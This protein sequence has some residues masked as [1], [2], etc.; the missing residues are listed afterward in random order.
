MAQHAIYIAFVFAL[1]AC[2]GSFL[3]VVVWRLPRVDYVDGEGVLKSFY[4][5]YRALSYPPS[6]CPKC[7]KPLPWYDNVPVFG[8][9]KLGGKCR[10]CKEPIS[11]RYPIVE[12][13]TGGIFVLYYV[14]FFFTHKGPC[15]PGTVLSVPR[16]L[17]MYFL[18]MSLLAALLAASLID[19]ELFIIPLEI[20][21][22]MA[23]V[24]FIVHTIFDH[25]GLPGALNVTTPAP[26]VPAI[27]AALA[28]GGFVGLAV[29]LILFSRGM[30]PLSFPEGEPIL[31]VDRPDLE[32]EMREQ[33]AEAKRQ[34]KALDYEAKLPPPYTSKQI[35]GE[36]RKEMLFLFPPMAG[37]VLWLVLTLKVTAIG[38]WWAGVLH[39]DW[40]T[41]L[42]GAIL[43]ALVGGWLVWIV[44]ILGTLGFGRV[45]MGLGDVHLMLGVGAVIGAGPVVVAFFLAPFFGILLAIYKLLIRSKQELPYGPYLS[46]GTAAVMLFYCPIA[47]YFRP[48]LQA[49]M[50]F[51]TGNES[52]GA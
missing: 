32:E 19:A 51:L 30:I 22:L 18:Y 28:A 49:L 24:G 36:I 43:G 10:F 15:A 9:I 17:W 52:T 7:D 47:D 29:S 25:P 23:V 4:R 5:S 42:L 2:V 45:A 34:G 40:L 39:H 48:G 41:G 27:G 6:H 38:H 26:G 16:D 50:Y 11:P 1:G 21:Y 12:A 13:I 33:T 44:R 31:E 46:L 37:A 14:L 20:P 3:N 8:W 35:R